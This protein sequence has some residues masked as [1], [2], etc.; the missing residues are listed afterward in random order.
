MRTPS[1]PAPWPPTVPPRSSSPS[2]PTTWPSSTRPSCTR[3][4]RAMAR[5]RAAARA[6]LGLAGLL[7]SP[8]RIASA[9]RYGSPQTFPEKL[10]I[11]ISGEVEEA[12]PTRGPQ[13]D[14][15]QCL[16]WMNV[17]KHMRVVCGQGLEMR[18]RPDA[19]IPDNVTVAKVDKNANA[20]II[21]MK[22][23]VSGKSRESYRKTCE[24]FFE[25]S[26][27]TYC[28]N[29]R[30]MMTSAQAHGERSAGSWCYVDK[31]CVHSKKASIVDRLPDTNVAV[32]TCKE[33][34]DLRL[35]DLKPTA[36]AKM[37]EEMDLDF[38]L[39]SGYSYVWE[40]ERTKELGEE[41]LSAIR[42]SG[43]PTI[44]WSLRSPTEPRWMVKG[45]QVFE[46]HIDVKK[47]TWVTKC[48]DGCA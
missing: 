20:Q 5:G 18:F 11:N 32:K 30:F 25:K 1:T 39:L 10:G 12:R 14:Y 42:N 6:L 36:L 34:K 8:P 31:G 23:A 13:P 46:Y 7:G 9:L 43:M 45:N 2:R 3:P 26:D 41:R 24:N 17:Y 33:R 48:I 27:H 44:I 29:E 19:N 40:E 38:G 4:R 37:G 22:M 35:S 47:N 28:I 15:C 16:N 21:F